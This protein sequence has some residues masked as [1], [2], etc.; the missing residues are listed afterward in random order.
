AL[1]ILTLHDA[2]P[3][4]ASYLDNIPL[5]GYFLPPSLSLKDLQRVEVLRGP[6][7]TLYGNASIGGLVRYITA[8]PDLAD[9]SLNLGVKVSQ[10]AE[11]DD[12]NYDTDLVIN[13]PLISDT[14]GVRLML[15][16]TENQGFIRSEEH[17]SELQSREN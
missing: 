9:A 17:T 11:S 7:G 8:R 15:G 12:L 2:L 13:T 10:T 1:S 5:Q 14:L 3:I 4:L 6:Q 16:K